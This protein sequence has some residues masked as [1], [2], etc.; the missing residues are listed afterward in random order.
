[1]CRICTGGSFRR[2]KLY[3]DTDELILT[4][5]R[6][7]IVN[8]IE[9]L[10]Q[11]SDLLDRSLLIR[12]EA[13]G[14]ERRRSET[15]LWN[16]FNKSYAQFFGAL[17]DTISVG[18]RLA[19]SVSLPTLPRMADFCCWGVAIEE[20]L[21]YAP[22]SFLA[23]YKGNLEDA[24][25]AAI[26]ASPVAKMIR[27]F[28]LVRGAFTGSALQL[29]KTLNEHVSETAET[30]RRHPKWPKSANALSAE[31]SRITPNLSKL[32]IAVEIGR[33]HDGRYIRLKRE[34]NRDETPKTV[35]PEATQHDGDSDGRDDVTTEG[36]TLHG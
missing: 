11:R 24:H 30:A 7:L 9:E 16:D 28:V 19:P 1:M 31:I 33:R 13:I 23:A 29:L 5:K 2:R 12:L 17:L 35:T 27:E 26:E 6:P 10:P 32:G 21:G 36:P 20:C 14:E 34:D 3:K 18:L 22:G 25:V 8:G 15:E 4:Y